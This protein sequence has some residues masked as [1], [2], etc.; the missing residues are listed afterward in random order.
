L[1]KWRDRLTHDGARHYDRRSPDWSP[2]NTD[3]TPYPTHAAAVE[4]PAAALCAGRSRQ[5][6]RQD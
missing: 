5:G 3:W 6:Q 1:L 4:S 2:D